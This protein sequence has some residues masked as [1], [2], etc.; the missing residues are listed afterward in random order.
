MNVDFLI[1]FLQNFWICFVSI[2]TTSCTWTLTSNVLKSAPF[3]IELRLFQD[4]G[5]LKHESFLLFFCHWTSHSLLINEMVSLT[6]WLRMT[7]VIA[8]DCSNPVTFVAEIEKSFVITLVI[9][10]QRVNCK[11][12]SLTNPESVHVT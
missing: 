2:I 11:F 3:L 6:R 1:T 5:V 12:L 7:S 9:S 4:V 10:R 8:N